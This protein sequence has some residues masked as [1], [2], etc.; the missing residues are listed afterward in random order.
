MVRFTWPK[1]RLGGGPEELRR[2]R[3]PRSERSSQQ[4]TCPPPTTQ[5]RQSQRFEPNPVEHAYHLN[6]YIVSTNIGFSDWL[7]VVSL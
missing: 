2:S 4:P 7:H 1:R 5:R 3:R 6:R